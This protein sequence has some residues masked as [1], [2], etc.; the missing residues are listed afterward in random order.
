M[1]GIAAE[2]SALELAAAIRAGELSIAEVTAAALAAAEA[3]SLGAFARVERGYA[4][5]AAAQAQRRLADG[6][7]APLL[8]V[9]CP[10]K[11]LTRVAGLGFEGGSRAWAD[12]VAEID[13]GIVTRLRAA[14]TIMIGKTSTPEFGLPCY[15]EPD[16]GPP[17]RTPWDRRR[18]AGG[19]SGGAA[20][21]VASGV[22]PLAHGSDGGGSIRIPAACCGLVGLKP[23]RGVIS[24]GPHGVDGP[25]LATQ[26]F[27]TRTVADTAAVLDAVAGPWPGDHFPGATGG[28]SV[29]L[30]E[31][32]R[33]L[34]V[35]LLTEP[36]LVPG[37]PVHPQARAAAE[38]AAR[39]L[40]EFGHEV[41]EAPV[42]FG[43]QEW[44]AF[45]A[46]WA[47]A[48]LSAPVPEGREDDLVPLTRWLRERG[49]SVT[50]QQYAE[51]IA[52]AQR[53]ER[54]VAARW[55]GFDVVLT[56]TLAQ[57][58]AMIGSLRDDRDPAADFAAQTAYTPWTSIYNL[59]GR[60]A[61]SIPLHRAE[62]DGTELPFGAMLGGP[63]GSDRLL[64]ALAA[65]L[66]AADPWPATP[67]APR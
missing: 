13:D 16:L 49:R 62:V 18:S 55:A 33:G 3:D 38:R 52:A 29:A 53:L 7:P 44:S 51:A 64:L 6:D 48:A 46:L 5:A 2:L 22:V 1:A 50:G 58:P 66:E 57:P 19:S 65:Q 54:T 17:A 59:V 27:L 4:E 45:E 41:S 31:R 34:R 12:N 32:V 36:V 37:A 14:G 10:V 28:F 24:P 26:G 30:A 20:A 63:T 15:T 42:P 43:P 21:A 23:S 56:P 47:V 25:G 67:P 61:I 9:P 40:G 11:D 35:G 39:L 8:G 60:P